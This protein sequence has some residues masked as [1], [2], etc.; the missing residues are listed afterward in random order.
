MNEIEQMIKEQIEELLGL[1]KDGESLRISRVG[2][3][4]QGMSVISIVSTETGQ[5]ASGGI[6]PAILLASRIK[7]EKEKKK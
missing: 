5:I 6:N 2:D 7:S 1:L 4:G 3:P